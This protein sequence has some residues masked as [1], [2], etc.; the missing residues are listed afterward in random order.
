MQANRKSVKNPVFP[1]RNI[2]KCTLLFRTVGLNQI[3]HIRMPGNSIKVHLMYDILE[4][5]R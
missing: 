2:R 3:D 1:Q 5:I 4:E